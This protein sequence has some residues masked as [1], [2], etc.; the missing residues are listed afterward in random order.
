MALEL[1][2]RTGQISAASQPASQTNKPYSLGI[3]TSS[4]DCSAPDCRTG[5]GEYRFS[6]LLLAKCELFLKT[7]VD[8]ACRLFG[9]LVRPLGLV[10]M[11][12]TSCQMSKMCKSH[13]CSIIY[14]SIP[15]LTLQ[16]HQQHRP[17]PDWRT[18][19]DPRL[20][21]KHNRPSRYIR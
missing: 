1:T 13:L 16:S 5:W 2:A 6:L 19:T 11:Y 3:I 20:T 9:S 4:G 17:E 18:C 10:R 7:R 8:E 12:V 14:P 15:I 21:V